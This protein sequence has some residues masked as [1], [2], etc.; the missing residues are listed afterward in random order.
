M[1]SAA[2][3]NIGVVGSKPGVEGGF[4]F[5]FDFPTLNKSKKAGV[6]GFVVFFGGFELEVA[7]AEG[8]GFE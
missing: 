4:G 6:T 8:K 7:N 2:V 3:L 1:E 5:D